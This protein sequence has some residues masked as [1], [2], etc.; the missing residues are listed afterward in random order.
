MILSSLVVGR[1]SQT[2]VFA[3]QVRRFIQ[4]RRSELKRSMVR[5][6]QTAR[7]QEEARRQRLARL[8]ADC[9][10]QVRRAKKRARAKPTDQLELEWQV[11]E[12]LFRVTRHMSKDAV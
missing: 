7:Q 2:V 6:V 4:Q 8:Q 12:V 10:Q 3:V 9:Q 1:L 5:E 11:R